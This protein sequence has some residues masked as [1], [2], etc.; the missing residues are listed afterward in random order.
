[1]GTPA[2]PPLDP[3]GDLP[4]DSPLGHAV[5]QLE[6]CLVGIDADSDA[7]AAHRAIGLAAV[8]EDLYAVLSHHASDPALAGERGHVALAVLEAWREEAARLGQDGA[9]H[10]AESLVEAL[11]DDEATRWRAQRDALLDADALDVDRAFEQLRAATALERDALARDRDDDWVPPLRGERAPIRTALAVHIATH[12]LETADQDRHAAELIDVA[13]DVLTSIDDLAPK[14]AARHLRLI[15]NDLQWHKHHVTPKGSDARKAIHRKLRRARIEQQERELQGRLERRFGTKNVTR[16]ERAVIW[17][18]FVVLGILLFEAIF[19]PPRNVRIALAVVDTLACLVFLTEFFV[20]LAMVRGKR[21]WFARHVLVDLLPSL[22]FSLLTLDHLTRADQTRWARAIRLLRLTRVTRYLRVLMPLIRM[23]RAFTF[24]SRG[25]DRLVRRYGHL[26]NR[27]IILFPTREERQVAYERTEG[28]A[29]RFWKLRSRLG[30]A[31]TTLVQDAPPEERASILATR[32]DAMKRMKSAGHLARAERVDVAAGPTAIDMPADVFFDRM[33]TISAEEVEADM[34]PEFVRRA[35]RVARVFA[36]PPI[37]W[38]PVLR[39]LVPKLAPGM[40]DAEVT[41]ATSQSLA[42]GLRRQNDQVFWFADLYGTVTPAEFVD[43]V[44]SAI[45]KASKRPVFRLVGLGLVLLLVNALVHGLDLFH[46]NELPGWLRALGGGIKSV[47]VW[48]GGASLLLLA[49]GW[50]LKSIAGQ[51]TD[52]F[53]QV[54]HAQYIALTEVI[55][56]RHL[57]RDTKIFEA[58]VLAH[59]SVVNPDDVPAT[60][61]EREALF[62]E[63][64]HGWMLAATPEEHATT[65]LSESLDRVVMLYRDALDGALLGDNDV[66]TTS[67]L[68]GDPALQQMRS[69]SSRETRQSRREIERLDLSRKRTFFGG[70][71]LWLSFISKSITQHVARLIVDYNRHAIAEADLPLS[72]E[73][74]RAAYERWLVGGTELAD[75]RA[76]LDP[77][78]IEYLTTSFKA[79]HFLDVDPTRDAEVAH[80]YGDA[81]LAKLKHDRPRAHS[82]SVQHVSAAHEAQV[83]SGS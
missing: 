10:D 2:A 25:L 53:T 76:R 82:R 12:P 21:S 19:D 73:R 35:A 36:R 7:S 8:E 24:L 29:S 58:R 32:I 18:I 13:D 55:K 81:L 49:F 4:P 1:M 43:R 28:V 17:L 66:R 65:P 38:F 26:L 64:V 72:R 80:R 16:F 48:L 74:E 78:D 27:N 33:E 56:G 41:A 44:G 57:D 5:T 67:Q 51:A 20:K 23:I 62:Q 15:A 37:R 6:D 39:K 42:R 31:W 46:W 71:Y 11:V 3:L 83:P 77:R 9:A 14:H 40:T 79:L 30:H 61:V 45:Y 75:E 47:V 63:A 52:F 68:L 50:W 34:G 69:L 70:P 59:E 22:P 60:R 54:A